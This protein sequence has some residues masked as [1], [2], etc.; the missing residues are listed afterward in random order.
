MGV[1]AANVRNGRTEGESNP[2][3]VMGAYGRDKRNDN[4]RRS[5]PAVDSLPR[6]RSP[7][8]PDAE[9]RTQG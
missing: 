5:Q 4:R 1:I 6:T 3:R 8:D 9:Y 2:D 7:A